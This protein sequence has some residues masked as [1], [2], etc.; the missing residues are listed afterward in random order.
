[1]LYGIDQRTSKLWA[2]VDEPLLSSNNLFVGALIKVI[3]PT[4]DEFEIHFPR[5]DS[6]QYKGYTTQGL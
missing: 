5:K 6:K 3:E 4:L 1:M 2:S